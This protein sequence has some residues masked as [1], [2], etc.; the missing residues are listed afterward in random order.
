MPSSRGLTTPSL[1]QRSAVILAQAGIQ[2]APTGFPAC[3]RMTAL[4]ARMAAYG[5]DGFF[6]VHLVFNVYQSTNET[7]TV[8]SYKSIIFFTCG[9][10]M[11]VSF[12]CASCCECSCSSCLSGVRI[13]AVV[14]LISK[15][16]GRLK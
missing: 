5:S 1:S 7:S 12:A 14:T 16:I 9:S 15:L 3:A 10:F 6:I 2:A 11:I 8:A 4:F 13:C